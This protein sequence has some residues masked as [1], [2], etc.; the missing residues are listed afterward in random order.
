MPV[1]QVCTAAK[2][3]QCYAWRHAPKRTGERGIFT[4]KHIKTT[5]IALAMTLLLSACAQTPLAQGNVH[6]YEAQRTDLLGTVITLSS[7]MPIS[8]EQFTKAFSIVEAIEEQMSV[9]RPNSE[10]SKI[11]QSPA[12]TYT[13]VS[14]QVQALINGALAVGSATQGAFDITIGAVMDLWNV[15]GRFATRP[16]DMRIAH[17]LAN[18]DYQQVEVNENGVKLN[19]ADMKL[20]LGGIAKGYACDSVRAYL[21]ENGITSALLDFGGN[22]YAHGTKQDGSD[23]KV[24]IKSPH[25]GENTLACVLDVRDS[26]VVTSGGYQRYFEADGTVY[27][28]IID[29]KTG[30]PVENGLL[31]VSI[32]GASSTLCDALSTACFVLGAQRGFALLESMENV[33]GVFITADGRVYATS[34]LTGRI[35]LL[36]ERLQ[37]ATL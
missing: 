15:N 33:E 31:S 26:A 3:C 14:P 16:S 2:L 1:A 8:Q 13:P 29:P 34:G 7:E 5:A 30:Y 19:K 35:T 24:G 9:N 28:H 10:I 37:M 22:I 6:A 18:V 17:K 21:Q 12:G 4:M 32:V 20:D 25:I 27:H 23:W 11:N 36:D